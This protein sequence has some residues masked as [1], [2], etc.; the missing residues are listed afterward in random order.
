MYYL[1]LMNFIVAA[2]RMTLFR[3]I[4]FEVMIL[5]TVGKHFLLFN[6]FHIIL[7][8]H[9]TLGE[10]KKQENDKKN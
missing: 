4:Y 9:F 2:R 5:R 6:I 3:N 8:L 7:L 10:Q 1:I